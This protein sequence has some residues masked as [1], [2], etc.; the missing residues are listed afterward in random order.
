MEEP[1]VGT[2]LDSYDHFSRFKASAYHTV[3]FCILPSAVK[4]LNFR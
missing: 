2:L 4:I 3:C 1:V